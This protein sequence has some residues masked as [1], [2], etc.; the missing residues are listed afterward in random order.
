MIIVIK[1]RGNKMTVSEKIA[2][3]EFAIIRKQLEMIQEKLDDA[4]ASPEQFFR[5]LA[6]LESI[7]RNANKAIQIIKG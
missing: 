2:Q 1:K 4:K 3:K 6:N 5:Q 7:A